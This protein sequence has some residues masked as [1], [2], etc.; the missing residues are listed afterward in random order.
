[1]IVHAAGESVVETV[2]D[3][4]YAL[5]LQVPDEAALVR[6]ADRLQALGAHVVR[7]VEDAGPFAGQLMALGLRPAPRGGLRRMLSSLP[8]LK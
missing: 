1:M 4:T 3:G 2:P 7:V 8:L 5:V 6:E